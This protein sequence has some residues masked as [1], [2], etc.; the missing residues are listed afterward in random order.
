MTHLVIYRI[1]HDELH[2]H[3]R[4]QRPTMFH[5]QT[6]CPGHHLHGCSQSPVQLYSNT[7]DTQ[8]RIHFTPVS[9]RWF[10]PPKQNLPPLKQTSCSFFITQLLGSYLLFTRLS[11]FILQRSHYKCS[12]D[13]INVS[14]RLNWSVCL[15]SERL[16]P[17]WLFWW[18]VNPS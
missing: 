18:E 8:I 11:L 6:R 5:Y 12:I 16:L 7:D 9:K 4:A 3:L 15:S 2:M 1:K 13:I 14:W 10:A 17:V